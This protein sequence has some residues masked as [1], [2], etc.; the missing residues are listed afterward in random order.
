MTHATGVYSLQGIN[1]DMP[2]AGMWQGDMLL[3]CAAGICA[4]LPGACQQD[5]PARN[6]Y[7]QLT[8]D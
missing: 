7:P 3:C 8:G 5:A 6:K 4:V 2:Q 1:A